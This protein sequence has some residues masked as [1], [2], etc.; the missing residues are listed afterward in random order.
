M[1]NLSNNK[2][3]FPWLQISI[4]ALILISI[5]G[6]YVFK[7]STAANKNNK[8]TQNGSTQSNEVLEQKLAD[9]NTGTEK[10]LPEQASSTKPS[11]NITSSEQTSPEAKKALPKLVDLGANTCIP[12]KEMAPILEEL[13]KEYSGIVDVEVVD[14]YKDQKIA[15]E[16]NEKHAI[17]LI[18]TQ[19]LFDAN[20]KE[21][22]SNEGFIPKENIIKVFNEKLGIK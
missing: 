2:K 4:V 10:Q 15:M 18:P 22:W 12:C 16:Y 21:V 9:S 17:R 5:I 7:N 19:I 6:I 13:K 20:G 1:S 14:V 11:G 8:I 3:S